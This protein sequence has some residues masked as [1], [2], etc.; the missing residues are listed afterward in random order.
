MEQPRLA[1]PKGCYAVRDIRSI[2]EQSGRTTGRLGSTGLQSV[3]LEG[4]HSWHSGA[5][6]PPPCHRR[7]RDSNESVAVRSDSE[8]L[9]DVGR[10]DLELRGLNDYAS[11]GNGPT[12]QS[13][14]R[15]SESLLVSVAVARAGYCSDYP[16]LLF[17]LRST[18]TVVTV[19]DRW[20][21][22][23]HRSFFGNDLFEIVTVEEF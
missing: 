22:W 8:Q 18:V 10:S 16:L 20:F 23:E 9:A 21:E 13:D 7:S 3:P 15:D 17:N 1:R 6:P 5:H 2:G 11:T 12:R 14:A 4:R 19:G